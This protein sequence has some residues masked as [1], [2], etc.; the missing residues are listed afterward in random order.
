MRQLSL[1]CSLVA[2]VILSACGNLAP[3]ASTTTVNVAMGYI[4]DVQFA[5]FY[6]AQAKGYYAA[7]GLTVTINHNDIRDALVQVGQGQLQ[8]ANASG[9]EILLARAQSI[10]VKLVFQTF[11]QFPIAVFSKQ[12]QGIAQPGDLR[13]KTVGIPGRFGATYVGLKALLHAAKIPEAEV[14]ITEIG[15]TQAAAIREDKVA[16]AVGY[17]NNE[18][19]LLQNEGTPVNVIRVSDYIA[20]VSN[21]LVASE[22]MISEQPETVRKFARATGRGLQDTL[23]DPDAAFKLALTFIPELKAELQPQELRKLKETL[24]LWRSEAADAN[25][26]GYSDPQAWQ[27]TYRFLRESAILDRD[28]DVEQAFTNDLRK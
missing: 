18:P 28:L 25:G 19:L 2:L 8:F 26:L 11:Q 24:A 3:T 7:E 5:P 13:G 15:F 16:A 12:S 17:F 6:V 23:D 27:T 9:D 22:K 21:G 1:L 20:L 14:Q 4:P 10:P